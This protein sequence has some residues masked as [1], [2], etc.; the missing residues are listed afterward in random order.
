MA[1][2]KE[3]R[4]EA[5]LLSAHLKRGNSFRPSGVWGRLIVRNSAGGK[6]PEVTGSNLRVKRRADG[7]TEG[8]SCKYVE[9][10]VPGL[11]RAE[12]KLVCD[13]APRKRILEELRQ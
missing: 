4:G 9:V 2:S 13:S 11:P 7:G 5:P 12:P 6:L 1:E 8:S 3:M 10:V